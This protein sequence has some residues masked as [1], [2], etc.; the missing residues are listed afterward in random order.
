MRVVFVGE[1][2]AGAVRETVR[3]DFQ[4]RGGLVVVVFVARGEEED[5]EELLLQSESE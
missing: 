2:V 1:R 5:E 3:W 4:R